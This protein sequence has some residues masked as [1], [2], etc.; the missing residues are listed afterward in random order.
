MNPRTFPGPWRVDT[1][2]GG[3]FVIR[4]ANGFPLAYVYAKRKPTVNGE[5]LTPGQAL[6]IAEAIAKLPDLL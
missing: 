3:H 2:A 4:D 5:D 1:T 6:M